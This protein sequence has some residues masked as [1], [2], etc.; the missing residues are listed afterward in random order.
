MTVR[1]IL[2]LLYFLCGPALVIVAIIGLRQ[3]KILKDVARVSAK[4]ESYRL[5]AE[6]CVYYAD[7]VIPAQNE[8]D[9]AIEARELT[10]FDES[11]ARIEGEKITIQYPKDIDFQKLTS[12][13][14]QRGNAYNRMNAFSLF[15]VSGV[16]DES[17]GFSSVGQTFCRN[18]KKLLPD[19]ML[20]NRAAKA[21]KNIIKL[22]LIWNARLQVESLMRDKEVLENKLRSIDNKEIRPIGTEE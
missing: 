17:V 11:K 5:A 1:D 6:Q 7:H 15:F 16:A 4:R 21:Y 8:L 12:I 3:L 10:F 19:I 22:F 9:E 18:V 2:E 13:S 20:L 14:P